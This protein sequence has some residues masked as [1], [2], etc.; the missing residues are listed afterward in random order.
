MPTPRFAAKASRLAVRR[1]QRPRDPRQGQRSL[2]HLLPPSAAGLFAA[3]PAARRHNSSADS[4]SIAEPRL[5]Q[6]SRAT[7]ICA[8]PAPGRASCLAEPPVSHSSPGLPSRRCIRCP[9]DLPRPRLDA[10]PDRVLLYQ[11]GHALRR[12]RA[13]RRSIPI[14]ATEPAA[15]SVSS[16]PLSPNV[17]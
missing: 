8:Y 17:N 9:P 6:R 10:H 5:H 3:A 14:S 15:K 16:A 7:R 11:F 2:H 4:D 1:L 13:S 12:D